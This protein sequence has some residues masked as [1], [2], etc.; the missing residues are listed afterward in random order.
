MLVED[1]VSCVTCTLGEEGDTEHL[2]FSCPFAQQRWQ[3]LG[4]A[5]GTTQSLIGRVASARSQQQRPFFMG[6]KS[7]RHLGDLEMRNR[8]VFDNERYCAARFSDFKSQCRLQSERFK[9]D[10]RTS[11]FVWLDAFS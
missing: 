1:E 2:F 5:L 3:K 11:F 7:D 6:D 9:K 4:I 8:K 10:G